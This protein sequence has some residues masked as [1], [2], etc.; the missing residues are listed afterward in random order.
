MAVDFSA[1]SSTQNSYQNY[2]RQIKDRNEAASKSYEAHQPERSNGGAGDVGDFSTR[3][4][5]VL[6]ITI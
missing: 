2:L 1:V 5:R 6:D 3:T 4:K